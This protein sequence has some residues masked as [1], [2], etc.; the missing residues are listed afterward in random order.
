[1]LMSKKRI[2]IDARMY[3]LGFTGIGRYN[4]E[5]IHHL[6]KIDRENEYVVFLRKEAFLRFKLPNHRFEKVLAD[7]G[8]YTFAEQIQFLKLLNAHQLHLMHFTHFNLPILYSRPYIVTIHDLTPSFFPGKK[9]N[10]LWHKWAYQLVLRVLAKRSKKIIS[11]SKHTKKDVVSLLGVPPENIEVV[12]NG[13]NSEF[14]IPSKT[15]RSDLMKKFG[16]QKPYLLYT[17]VWRSHKNIIGL[18]KAFSKVNSQ[19]G[20]QYNLVI[21]GRHNPIYNEIPDIVEK[22]D[23]K[24]S[25]HL[26]GMVPEEDL[27]A[28]YQHALA[29]TFPS[30]YEGFGLPPLESMQSNTPV[31]ASNT[32]SIP[33]ICG[34]GNALFFDP[35]SVDDMV[36]KIKKIITDAPLRQ[37]LVN[38]GR[39]RVKDFSWSDMASSVLDIYNKVI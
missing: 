18:I 22:L 35:Y 4:F 28:L 37:V 30:F 39:L 9:M 21:T 19:L 13:V 27:K 7:F 3:G 14:S 12:Y 11:I 25:V 10:R 2:G 6:A 33:E 32:T 16:L 29:Y 15:S 8:H 24:E 38:K 26:V 34:W 1:M 5:L 17:G 23:L 36:K 20:N 31:V